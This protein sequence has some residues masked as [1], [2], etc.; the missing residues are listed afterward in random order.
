MAL[1]DSSLQGCT[2]NEIHNAGLVAAREENAG[3]SRPLRI[4]ASYF[5][6]SP[7][8]SRDGMG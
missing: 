7:M 4:E 2:F 8:L 1:V 6:S 5:E 3:T